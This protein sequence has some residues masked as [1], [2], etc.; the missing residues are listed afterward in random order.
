MKKYYI[1]LLFLIVGL[2]GCKKN[3][4]SLISIEKNEELV[5]A[6][7]EF[8][9]SLIKIIVNDNKEIK[10]IPVTT[11]MISKEDFET[12]KTIGEHEIKIKYKTLTIK[13][14][15]KIVPE[16]EEII[17]IYANQDFIF[18]LSEFKVNLIKLIVYD[19]GKIKEIELSESMIASS[20]LNKLKTIGDHDIKVNYKGISETIKVK[21]IEDPYVRISFVNE[22][23]EIP[24]MLVEKGSRATLPIPSK[25][26]YTFIGWYTGEGVNDG[27]FDNSM[28]VDKNITLYARYIHNQY[29]ISFTDVDDNLSPVTVNFDGQ[30]DNLPKPTRAGYTFEGW[31]YDDSL[32]TLPLTFQYDHNITIKP[33]WQ[34]NEYEY[35]VTDGTVTLDK[36]LGNSQNV[37]IPST[38]NQI[39][40]VKLNDNL[41]NS[42]NILS[43][44]ISRNVKEIGNKTF[45]LVNNLESITVD[46]NNPFYTASDSV[47]YNKN[48]TILLK[49]PPFKIA[50][51]YQVPST[52]KTIDAYA[53]NN[54]KYLE[55]I[56]LPDGLELIKEYAFFGS[57]LKEVTI[58]KTVSEISL[59]TFENCTN[60]HKVF[61]EEGSIL[62]IIG[63]KAFA[64][65][66]IK[67]ITLPEMLISIGKHAFLNITTLEN[68]YVNENNKAYVDDE[69]VLYSENF[70]QLLLYPMGR[71]NSSYQVNELTKIISDNSFYNV[72]NLES[73]TL[74]R[75]LQKIDNLA[76]AH[77]N[78]LKT[79][80][81]MV[82]L[83]DDLIDIGTDVFFNNDPDLKIYLNPDILS[84][85][86]T[87][88]LRYKDI[89]IGYYQVDFVCDDVIIAT[90]YVYPGGIATVPEP[91]AKMGYTFIGWD[92][93]VSNITSNTL[94]KAR[95]EVNLYNIYFITGG[96]L[97]NPLINVP[98][99]SVITLPIPEKPGY[100]F[101]KWV[102]NGMEIPNSFTFKFT[103]DIYI[104]A[105]WK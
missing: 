33:L 9:I 43:I 17:K 24:D 44:H 58:P 100:T 81:M 79:I 27:K 55:L 23:M 73:I 72:K 90:D 78:K 2:A 32:I 25:R 82:T 38:I 70:R 74:P 105:V 62:Q 60:L 80:I 4:Q 103:E 37:I 99:D 61:F 51:H 6:K 40:V 102:V 45:A 15:V 64:N 52:V 91:K 34:K 42:S 13:I 8:D 22:T 75:S 87:H 1:L 39:P 49:Y 92:K 48:L 95:Y 31:L 69:G 85:Y 65:T 97:I 57:S 19:E 66:V 50:K 76:F 67:N 35:T 68:I 26:G 28:I 16:K 96:K 14:I 104:E 63:M 20:D 47:L 93:E 101:D 71:P 30:I 41:F 86:Q 54:V 77:A 88:W 3:K 56:S 36:Y 84:L 94:I 46:E 83:E 11:D 29:L 59:S 18:T 10:K 21:I 12:L 89:L 7:S 53:F 5:F 98:Y